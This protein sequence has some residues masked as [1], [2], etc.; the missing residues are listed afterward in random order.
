MANSI[1]CNYDPTK[2]TLKRHK[3]ALDCLQYDEA[4]VDIV[5][6]KTKFE[7]LTNDLTKKH[8]EKHQR[9]LK[10]NDILNQVVYEN[11]Y[12]TGSVPAKIYGLPKMHKST[13]SDLFPKLRPILFFYIHLYLQ[14]SET[15]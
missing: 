3:I 1:K 5:N 11:V 4:T 9:L 13:Q 12:P 8:E 6:D 15:S 2:S 14:V 7:K 10:K